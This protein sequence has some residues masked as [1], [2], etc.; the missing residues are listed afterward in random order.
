VVDLTESVHRPVLDARDLMVIARDKKLRTKPV[1]IQ[2]LWNHDLRVFNIGG[3]KDLS[4]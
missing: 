2:T 4:T 3:K 1:E